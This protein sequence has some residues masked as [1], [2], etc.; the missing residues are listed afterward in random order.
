MSAF[1]DIDVDYDLVLPEL[2]ARLAGVL[3]RPGD[4]AWD[5]AR[6]AGQLA[7][8]QQPEAVV[9]AARVDDVVTVVDTARCVGL[10]VAP[11]ATGHG[12]A[13]LGPLDG[14]ILLKTRALRGVRVDAGRRLAR[15]E[16]G[17]LWRDVV[18]R[19]FEHGLTALA[20][21]APDVG[22]V[23]STLGGGLS[24]HARSLGLA[25]DSITAVELVTADGVVRRADTDHEPELFR[26]VRV[27]GGSFGV[28]TALEFRL[29]PFTHVYAG[30]L[31]WPIDRAGD[32]LPA[33]RRWIGTV[34]DEV[35]SLG[36][37]LRLPA[38]PDLAS[39]LRGRATVAVE[40]VCRM[41]RRD[42]E[43]LLAPLRSLGP[44]LDT[45]RPTPTD[46]L[47]A[48]HVALPSPIPWVGDGMFLSDLTPA[49]ID[50]VIAVAGPD[51]D[52][53]LTSVELRHLG[54]A[55]RGVDGQVLVW[56]VGAAADEA[57][58]RAVRA[59]VDAVQTRLAPWSTHRCSLEVAG[60]HKAGTALF[61]AQTYQWLR[62]VKTAY[63]PAD[64]IRSN[65][66]VPPLPAH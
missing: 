66:P 61:G 36:R 24:W 48:L 47:G 55:V 46:Q 40:A 5:V 60:R 37:L 57:D 43:S 53:P 12:A 56:G 63:D 27:G 19:A 64:V 1:P 13:S 20:G 49:A 17:A 59:G 62:E 29:Y 8:D 65:H 14:T 26:A 18:P 41:P 7:V 38:R 50:A 33:W 9:T 44:E 16:A 23:G 21:G 51:A 35:T 30:V 32:V 4:D 31:G 58:A 3:V 15:V 45:F 34:P 54:G 42:A 52:C 2:A 10:R 28:V 6:G 11:Q 25:A 22:V 39:A